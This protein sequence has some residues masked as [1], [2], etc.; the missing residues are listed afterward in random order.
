MRQ[1]YA[2]RGDLGTPV[3]NKLEAILDPA[4]VMFLHASSRD[5]AI[6]ALVSLLQ[7]NGLLPDREAFKQAILER[8]HLVSTGIG[9]GVAVPHA[10]LPCFETFFIAIGI[11]QETGIE[12]Q[13]LDHL[14]VRLIFMIGGPDHKQ[15]E[16]LQILSQ[17]TA[18]VRDPEI[19]RQLLTAQDSQ[20]I[21]DLLASQ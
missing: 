2:E 11:Q 13:S 12:W 15:T 10:K 7:A 1:L 9:L 17:L 16:Y 18:A 5:E 8:E 3:L 20:Q 14:P 4:L 19:R 21:L 6:E